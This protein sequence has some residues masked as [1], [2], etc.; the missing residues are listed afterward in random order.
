MF[1]FSIKEVTSK[2]QSLKRQDEQFSTTA[3]IPK[4]MNKIFGFYLNGLTTGEI[5]V[6]TKIYNVG[7]FLGE[8]VKN[9]R[10]GMFQNL[11][12]ETGDNFRVIGGK[13]IQRLFILGQKG[14]VS[15]TNLLPSNAFVKANDTLGTKYRRSYCKPN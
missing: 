13:Q 8:F 1:V 11:V 10:G 2:Y 3:Q 5:L 9:T 4:E 14:F 7:T 15:N 12:I 6:G